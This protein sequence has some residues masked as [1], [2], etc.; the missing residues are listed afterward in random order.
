MISKNKARRS[1]L[2]GQIALEKEFRGFGALHS[3]LN[4]LLHAA[5]RYLPMYPGWRVSLHRLR[6]VKVGRRVFIGSDVFIDNTYPESITIEDDVTIISRSFIIGHNFIPRHLATAL[7]REDDAPK[8]GVRFKK[9]CYI[10]AQCIILPGVTIGECAVVGAGSI[11][12]G[13][14][15]EFSIA[16]GSPAKVTGR[17]D[18]A[19]VRSQLPR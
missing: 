15:P 8:R 1:K 5:A 18:R 19:K 10:G 13:D 11:V 2:M 9:G 16:M 17:L 14:I 3:V 4:R 12:T 6:G 7:A